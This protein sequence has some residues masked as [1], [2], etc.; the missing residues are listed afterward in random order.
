M[1]RLFAA[2]LLVVPV[3]AEATQVVD[4]FE[5]GTNPNAWGWSVSGAPYTIQPQGGDPGAWIDSGVPYKTKHAA[6]VAVPPDGSALRAA[7]A[8]G[9]LT[10]ASIAIEELDASGVTGCFPLASA[11]GPFTLMFM[12]LHSAPGGTLIEAH[13]LNG[14]STPVAPFPWHTAGFPIPSSDGDDVPP[15]WR[16]NNADV[17]GYTWSTMMHN[18]DGIAFYVDDPHAKTFEGCWHMGADNVVVTYGGAPDEIFADAFEVL[19]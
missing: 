3:V 8:S 12:D 7:L 19:P 11:T 16:L 5:S 4:D 10:S 9:T 14:P 17:P 15:G 13:T 18:I 2:L 1:S 6:L